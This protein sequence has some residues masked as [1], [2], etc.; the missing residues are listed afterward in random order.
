MPGLGFA[1]AVRKFADETMAKEQAIFEAVVELA[2]ESIVNGSML[3]GS[4]GQP[5]STRQDP[6]WGH[7]KDSWTVT[8]RGNTAHIHTGHPGAR[9]IEKGTRLGKSLVLHYGNG[10]FHSV[11]LTKAGFMHLVSAAIAQVNAGGFEIY[12]SSSEGL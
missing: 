6:P 10:G 9:T 5:E 4:P 8:Y 3:T 11:E 2:Y 1:D 12:M 7:L